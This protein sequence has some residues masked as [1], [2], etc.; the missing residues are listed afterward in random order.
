[1]VTC[2][3]CSKIPLI[4]NELPVLNVREPADAIC[5]VFPL[6]I[7]NPSMLTV[8]LIVLVVEPPMNTYV[9]AELPPVEEV[10]KF[11]ALS[12]M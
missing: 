11:P 1:M 8:E 10:V 3:I 4:V 5:N 6:G 2:P 12:F 7:Y 9:L